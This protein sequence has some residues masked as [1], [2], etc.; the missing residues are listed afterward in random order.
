[1]DEKLIDCE[2][3]V[4]YSSP[5]EFGEITL[6]WLTDGVQFL[7]GHISD[8]ILA[9][10]PLKPYWNPDYN[11]DD[12]ST[13]VDPPPLWGM[14]TARVASSPRVKHYSKPYSAAGLKRLK[15]SAA[16]ILHAEITLDR[17]AGSESESYVLTVEREGGES[18]FARLMIRNLHDDLSL[19]RREIRFMR[20][21]ADRC[22]PVFGHV[23]RWMGEL[24]GETELECALNR[25]YGNA[26]IEWGRYLRGYSWI[27]VIPAV[28][29]NLLGGA[30]GLRAT[31][32]FAAVD[33]V[34]G[35]SLWLLATDRWS[36][37]SG[38]QEIIDHMFEV[39]APVLPPGTPKEAYRKVVEFLPGNM[40]VRDIPYL[41]S[42]RDAA[43]FQSSGR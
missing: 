2:L 18:G 29:A 16:D 32:A 24:P 21:F 38:N 25:Y 39:L 33:E 4:A 26:L 34:A 23:S 41:L 11:P 42:I 17:N 31:G 30:A 27:T 28:L 7:G 5:G 14:V 19:E 36:D 40:R 9:G 37:F 22:T 43:E 35:G 10:P 15:N 3:D 1:M 12:P 8:E 20:D 6:E 13:Y